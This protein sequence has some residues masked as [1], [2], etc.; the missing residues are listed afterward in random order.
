MIYP[1]T[2]ATMKMAS[3]PNNILLLS[4]LQLIKNFGQVWIGLHLSY[5]LLLLCFA[6]S[7]CQH[8]TVLDWEGGEKL[9]MSDL[10]NLATQA[11]ISS[12]VEMTGTHSSADAAEGF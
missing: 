9:I 5:D 8:G 12:I 10:S 1:V 7:T 3:Y 11:A 2:N 4:L 6:L